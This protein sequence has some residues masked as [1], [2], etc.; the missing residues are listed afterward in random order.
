MVLIR[1]TETSITI[2]PYYYIIYMCVCVDIYTKDIKYKEDCI[3]IC[4]GMKR[5]KKYFK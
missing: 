4:T 3:S 1:V 2:I 5:Y